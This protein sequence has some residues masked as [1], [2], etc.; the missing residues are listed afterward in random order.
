MSNDV[1]TS[2]FPLDRW[3]RLAEVKLKSG[4]VLR[5]EAHRRQ[6]RFFKPGRGFEPCPFKVVQY[7]VEKR[8][9]AVEK[10]K[11]TETIYRWAVDEDAAVELESTSP[12]DIQDELDPSYNSY[13][14]ASEEQIDYDTEE[15]SDYPEDED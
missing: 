11:T 4:Y 3:L 14:D 2:P 7:L 12:E 9:L 10:T 15:L 5:V 6:A 8:L 1:Y 13:E